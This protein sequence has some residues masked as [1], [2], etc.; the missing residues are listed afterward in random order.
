MTQ[1]VFQKLKIP[2]VNLSLISIFCLPRRIIWDHSN[3]KWVK[4]VI[5]KFWY[6]SLEVLIYLFPVTSGKRVA[7]PFRHPIAQGVTYWINWTISTA[8]C[9]SWFLGTALE[10]FS[11]GQNGGEKQVCFPIILCA[12]AP[13]QEYL[14]RRTWSSQLGKEKWEYRIRLAR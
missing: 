7:C 4:M 9:N 3:N 5:Q 14:C 1:K 6:S 2:E 11:K 10:R 13:L 8:L 12:L